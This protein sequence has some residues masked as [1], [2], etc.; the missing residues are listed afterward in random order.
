MSELCP[1]HC[2]N[3]GCPQPSLLIQHQLRQLNKANQVSLKFIDLQ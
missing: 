3:A 2:I 1:L